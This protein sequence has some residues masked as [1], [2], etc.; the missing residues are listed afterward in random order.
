[1][2]ARIGN[3]ARRLGRRHDDDERGAELIEFALVVVLLIT[4]LYGIITYGLIL[5][6][7]ATITQ[8]AADAARSGIVSSSTAV[9]TAEAQACTDVGWMSK[10]CGTPTVFNTSTCTF[11]PNPADA[12]TA[13]ACT[14]NCPSNSVN[15]CLAVTVS[16]NYSSTPL[17]PELPGLGIITPSTISSTNVVQLST[18]SS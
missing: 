4:L 15:T 16:Y 10:T 3:I 17:F 12:I 8:A 5:G 6:A 14:E 2:G 1:M 11:S 9:A 13:F 7:Q 18:P